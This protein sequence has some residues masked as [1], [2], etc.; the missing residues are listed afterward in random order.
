MSIREQFPIFQHTNYLGSCSHGALSIQVRQA[1]ES[2]LNDRDRYG[3][4]WDFWVEQLETAR[5]TLAELIGCQPDEL[6]VTPSV[7]NAVSSLASGIDFT[8]ERNKIVCTDFDFPTTGQIWRAHEARGAEVVYV[9]ASEDG[10]TIPFE[11][12]EAMIDERTAVVSI[13]HVCYRNGAKL[14]IKPIV[15]LARSRGALVVL[16]SYQALGTIPI[17]VVELGVDVLLGGAQK[18]LL[19]SSGV[20]FMYVRNEIIQKLQPTTSGWFCQENINAMDIYANQPSMTAR[21]FEG[22]T[23]NV[24]N[25]YAVIAGVKL[26]Q[27]IGV[28]NIEKH[29]AELT[30]AL[31]AGVK[32]RGFKLATH[33]DGRYHGPMIAIK[34]TDMYKLVATLA[35]EGIVTSCR[36]GNLRVSMHIYNNQADIEQLLQALTKHKNLL[37]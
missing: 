20:G 18:Y 2:Y 27:S 13:P 11:N 33:P 25:L 12:F 23:P 17:D 5:S 3:A 29:I 19:G 35:E 10:T 7:S 15:E 1:Y 32:Q 16:D 28:D 8:G 36:D 34:S 21:R 9:K 37:A 31:K 6:A 4:R 30:E 24:P 26:I 22:G 14:D